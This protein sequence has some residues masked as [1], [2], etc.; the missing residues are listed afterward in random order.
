MYLYK[1]TR[2]TC[3]GFI[4]DFMNF[5]RLTTMVEHS[6]RIWFISESRN[7]LGDIATKWL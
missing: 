1:I 6:S 3:R 2:S 7:Y 4:E 5:Y